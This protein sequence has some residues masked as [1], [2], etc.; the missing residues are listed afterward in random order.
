MSQMSRIAVTGMA[1]NTPLGDSLDGFLDG[2]LNGRSAIGRW[3]TYDT[4]QIYSKVG[5]D[6]FDYDIDAKL[7]GLAESLPAVMGKR[8]IGLVGRA[9]W[10][11]KLS[12]LMTADAWLDSG[13]TASPYAENEVAVVVAGHNINQNYTYR[14]HLQF[15][16]DP[17]YIEGL[18]SLHGLDTDH[19]GSVSE[20]LQSRGP[21]YT[22]GAA[23]ASGNIALRNAVDEIRHHRSAVAVVVGAVLDFSPVDL[24]G[25][26][27]M[28]AIAH[29]NFNDAPTRASRPF[30]SDREG[31]V[32]A[33]GGGVLV[34]EDYERALTRGVR[35]YAEVL[36]V[37]AGS[38]GSHLP[39]PSQSGQV[40]AM[41]RAL[42]E[43][44]VTPEDVDYISAH[45][46]STPLG[47]LTELASIREVFG[48]HAHKI[49]INAPKSLLGHTCWAAPTVET[50]AA[51]LQ[52]R[53]GKLHG[54]ANIDN[55]DEAVDLDVCAD[56]TIDH[57]VQICMKNSFGFGGI[58]C[59]SVIR[60]VPQADLR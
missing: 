15:L 45:A 41:V 27:I 43:S 34:L 8:L 56:G 30:D 39:Q 37:A 4:A 20:M 6:L 14:N 26:A 40:A 25:M 53:E 11:V 21:I 60:N 55:I 16:D 47:D 31:F 46:T 5:A 18:F 51:I 29:R 36:G 50:V 17:E 12:L 49:K 1:V 24:Q 59:V 13:L 28:G 48:L 57:P 35:I 38:D 22:M 19:A 2:L 42:E 23:C 32:P 7:A 10:S 44:G 58:N 54:S 52:M 33:H 3:K 9:S